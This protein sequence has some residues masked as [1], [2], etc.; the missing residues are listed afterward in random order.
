M[1]SAIIMAAGKGT[2]MNSDQ[3]KVLHKLLGKTMIDYTV[4]KL[5]EIGVDNIVAVVGYQR[6]EIMKHLDNKIDFA[7][8][9]PQLGTG[10]AVSC[11]IQLKD[12]TGSTLIVNGD[13]PLITIDTYQKLLTAN[14]QYPLVVLTTLMDD[15]GSYGRVIRNKDDE[16][17]KIVEYKDCNLEEKEVKE[18][19]AGIYC[20]D[21]QLLWQYLPLLKNNNAQ[22]EY[23][24]TDLIDLFN[25]NGLKV[26][27]VIGDQDELQGINDRQ[28]LAQATKWLKN[29]VNNDLMQ[30]GVSIVDPDNTFISADAYIGKD[31]I[32]Y[33]NVTIEGKCII[34]ERNIIEAGSYLKDVSIA[35]DNVIKSSRITDS[36]MGSN[37]T[38]GPNSHLRNQCVIENNTR[39]GNFVE[40]KNVH[41][42]SGSKC[43][44]LTYVGDANVGE[45]CNFGCGVVTV[46]YDGKNK[47]HTEIGNHVFIGSN[48]NII[49]PVT[50]SDN[51]VLAAGS[52]ITEDVAEGDMAI[53][54]SRQEVI[55]GYGKKYLD[56]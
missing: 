14:K 1:I 44:H 26:G 7:I 12:K 5:K 10:H 35:N 53:A 20:V 43:A 27:A 48:V 31:S 4:D 30:Q 17:I 52:T 15:A 8:Q 50:I 33:P 28:Q 2:R 21:N 39:I 6:E 19:N 32:V 56:K 45:N 24:I 47:F 37:N 55:K 29:K 46:N 40:M 49:A 41:F 13:C 9:D 22:K 36:T 16:V 42:G 23:Y 38:L 54:R 18:I 51:V 11:A 25:S 3:P 34:G